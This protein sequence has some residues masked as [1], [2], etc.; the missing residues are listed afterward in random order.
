MATTQGIVLVLLKKIKEHYQP[1]HPS[2][3]LTMLKPSMYDDGDDEFPKLKGRASQ[4]R[5]LAPSLL[6]TYEIFM[7]VTQLVQRQVV[8]CLKRSITME[9]IL[10]EHEDAFKL[11]REKAALFLEASY[12]YLQVISALRHHFKGVR[13]FHITI[14]SHY[15]QHIA[16][17]AAWLNPRLSWRYMGEDFVGI[18]RNL[19]Q[20][21]QSGTPPRLVVSRAIR[22][23]C[24]GMDM[25]MSVCPWKP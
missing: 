14:K 10:D 19:I 4:I 12:D 15:L 7:D 8:I 18:V 2:G 25:Q 11:S 16:L 24:F 23:Y 5:H 9:D 3:Q 21:C 6:Y 20:T 13:L 17:S 22:K 1:T